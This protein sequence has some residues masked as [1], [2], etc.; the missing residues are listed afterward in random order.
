MEDYKKQ[1]GDFNIV[2]NSPIWSTF[3]FFLLNYYFFNSSSYLRLHFYLLQKA[4]N[5][6]PHS[7]L[8]DLATWLHT[9]TGNGTFFL[10]VC[11]FC[12][13]CNGNWKVL[14]KRKETKV[15]D[16]HLMGREHRAS[17]ILLF[18]GKNMGLKCL[19]LLSRMRKITL[20]CTSSWTWKIGR[21]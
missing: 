3:H 17:V 21:K 14:K 5:S 4:F 6:W 1:S 8:C 12:S 18:L 13:S 16:G 2:V 10:C 15:S 19:A 9:V 7:F 20:L 11:H